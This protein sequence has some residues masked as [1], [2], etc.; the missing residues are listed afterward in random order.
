MVFG[1]L[2]DEN[3]LCADEP[4]WLLEIVYKLMYVLCSNLLLH[5]QDVVLVERSV[6]PICQP[7]CEVRYCDWV[8]VSAGATVHYAE[9]VCCYDCCD[10]HTTYSTLT[11]EF[12]WCFTFSRTFY[13]WANFLSCHGLPGA[14]VTIPRST[15]LQRDWLFYNTV[16]SAQGVPKSDAISSNCSQL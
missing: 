2:A 5:R 7:I 10:N 12:V 1:H 4:S 15:Y 8:I 9:R 13:L 11:E 14:L 3:I 16:T 6:W